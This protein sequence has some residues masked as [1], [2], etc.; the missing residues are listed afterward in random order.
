M[1][2]RPFHPVTHAPMM[3]F[4]AT[5][6]ISPSQYR[7]LSESG[8][9]T[10]NR[11]EP[12]RL[13]KGAKAPQ[14]HARC[15][16]YPERGGATK[17]PCSSWGTKARPTGDQ[18]KRM[19]RGIFQQQ[20]IQAKRIE[21]RRLHANIKFEMRRALMFGSFENFKRLLFSDTWSSNT[22]LL[23]YDATFL[24]VELNF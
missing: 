9:R 3:V 22:L 19:E 16:G 12:S 21:A 4:V 7:D 6:T 20:N 24:P 10:H 18:K 5:V 13:K 15:L 17:N 14:W 1:N 23:F 8:S 11:P 2:A